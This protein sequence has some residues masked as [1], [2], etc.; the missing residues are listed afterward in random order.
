MRQLKH[1]QDPV[2]ALLGVWLIVAPWLLGFQSDSTVMSN[3]VV[4]G[5][6][7]TAVALGAVFLPQAW[8]EWTE[9][10]LGVWLAVSPWVLKF[11]TLEAARTNAVLVGV[12]VLVLALWVLLSDKDYG[13]M[14]DNERPA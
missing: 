12:A 11:T 14:P 2:S 4:V 9:V 1:W 10:A 13:L 7:L 5:I 8:E 3:H 6:A